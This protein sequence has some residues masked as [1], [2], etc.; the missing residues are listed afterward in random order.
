MYPN[1]SEIKQFEGVIGQ[2]AVTAFG[3]Y[4]MPT[5]ARNT[6]IF[7]KSTRCFD[8]TEHKWY[9]G[10]S[11]SVGGVAEWGGYHSVTKG[12]NIPD[13]LVLSGDWK[14]PKL[15]DMQLTS[16]GRLLY[17]SIS[18]WY[19]GGLRFRPLGTYVMGEQALERQLDPEDEHFKHN[20][21]TIAVGDM[22]LKSCTTAHSNISI[23]TMSTMFLET[24]GNNIA[25]GLFALNNMVDGS[26]AT[27]MQNCVGLGYASKVSGD[28]QVQLGGT[29]STVYA[30]N[31]IQTRSDKRDKIDIKTLDVGLK[32]INALKPKK[33]KMNFRDDYVVN[34]EPEYETDGTLKQSTTT[35]LENDGSKAGSRIHYGLLAQDVKKTLDD[36]GIDFAGYQDHAVNGGNDVLTLGYTEFIP[37]LMK[38]VQELSAEVDK[39]KAKKK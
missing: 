31:A 23:G 32:F 3:R 36:I 27:N 6:Y 16:D 37:I 21:N 28:N 13:G 39:L 35:I 1:D 8:T 34:S 12:K 24:G 2:S 25:F 33:Y 18:G 22:T 10:D 4:Q 17:R 7:P 30:Q 26:N 5:N 20:M 11:Q 38:A 9:N 14:N 29:S 19:R 15:G